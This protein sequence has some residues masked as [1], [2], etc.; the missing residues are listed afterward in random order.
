MASTCEAVCTLLGSPGRQCSRRRPSQ[1][2]TQLPGSEWAQRLQLHKRLVAGQQGG[3]QLASRAQSG[4]LQASCDTH[5]SYC[6]GSYSE[7]HCLII[8][9]RPP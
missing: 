8:S 6:K 7:I 2:G 9:I 1:V 4:Q 3:A 5:S